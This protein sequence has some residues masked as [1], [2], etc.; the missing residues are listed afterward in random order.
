MVAILLYMDL[1][2]NVGLGLAGDEWKGQICGKKDSLGVSFWMRA[3]ISPE[4]GVRLSIPTCLM[5]MVV[6]FF[7]LATHS[8]HRW[9]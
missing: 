7:V 9:R 5:R 8:L 1:D 6:V 3:E 2:S 4:L